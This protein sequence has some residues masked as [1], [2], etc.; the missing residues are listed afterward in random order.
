V[1]RAAA[2]AAGATRVVTNGAFF[3]R[4]PD[5][6]AALLGEGLRTED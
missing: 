6:I 4:M 1:G 2:T 5:M 3:N